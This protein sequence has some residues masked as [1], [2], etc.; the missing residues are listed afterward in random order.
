MKT[1][2]GG[3]KIVAL[4]SFIF[5]TVSGFLPNL[6]VPVIFWEW[7]NGAVKSIM[8]HLLVWLYIAHIFMAALMT[9]T[10]RVFLGGGVQINIY[11]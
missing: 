5:S 3:H 2:L 8:A 9:V 6:S 11:T 10:L 1:W 7:K 4:P